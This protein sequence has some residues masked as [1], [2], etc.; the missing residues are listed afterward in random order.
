MIYILSL[1]V[2]IIL[3]SVLY[4]FKPTKKN[5]KHIFNAEYYRGLNYLLNNEE[6]KAFKIFTALM[7]VD[8]STIETHLAL[9]GLYRKRGEFDKAILIHQNL[10]SRP[11]LELELKNQALYELAKDFHF[12]GLYD[13]S[14]KIF[15]NLA[16]IKSYKH[17]ALEHLIKI[18]E[19]TKDWERAIDLVK[20]LTNKS[21]NGHNA[22]SLLAQ[23]YC[24]IS[25]LYIDQNQIDKSIAITKKSLKTNSSCIR[26]NLQLADC[27]SS[28]D[29]GTSAQYYY[30]IINQ[31]PR[32][33]NLVVNKIIN[34]AKKSNNTSIVLKT[35]IS[36]SQIKDLDFIP[37]V[38]LF[39]YYE[40]ER[41]LAKQYIERFQNNDSMNNFM[42][43]HTL[44]SSNES[45]LSPPFNEL[46]SSY[47]DVF[48]NNL[49]FICSN[50]GY[51]TNELNWCCPS[52]NSWESMVPKSA[53]DLLKDGGAND[54]K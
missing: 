47:K 3:S 50:C 12:A 24:E 46:I 33:A 10:L 45:I 7:D 14:E 42:V 16:E 26:A 11:T 44:A 4:F 6:D 23:Y 20:S 2:V 28:T 17:S 38:Y 29:I 15:K 39:L 41:V 27:Y 37:D 48:V 9:G 43:K 30:S 21:V 53:L 8:S 51:K 36:I 52:C 5:N 49:H 31:D 40:D 18:Y 13:R 1:I 32:F 25:S 54:S 19:V 35:L 34:L 22:D